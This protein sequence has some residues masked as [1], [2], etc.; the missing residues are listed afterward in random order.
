MNFAEFGK[1]MQD[2]GADMITIHGRTRS[3]MYGGK[4]DW[5]IMKLLTE[6]VQIP[7][8]ANG[9]INNIEDAKECL[10]QSGAN[11]VAI[12]RG[13]LSDASLIHRIDNYGNA[14]YE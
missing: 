4:A 5:K 13:I 7:V 10:K 12:A 2:A 3:Q 6:N 11:G 14:R 8:F 1:V 9:D